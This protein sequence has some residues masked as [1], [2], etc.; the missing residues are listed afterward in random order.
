MFSPEQL[1][2]GQYKEADTRIHRL[3]ARIKLIC[4]LVLVWSAFTCKAG[5]L[6]A[7]IVTLAA[8]RLSRLSFRL[9]FKWVASLKWF[10]IFTLV[11]HTLATP[12][13][14]ISALSWGNGGITYEGLFNGGLVSLRL[15]ILL[16]ASSLLT[17]TT[18][19]TR[20]VSGLER[21]LSPLAKLGVP[22][23]DIAMMIMLS[24]H[25][26][27]IL[28]QEA[29]RIS[30]AQVARGVNFQQGNLLQRGKQLIPLIIPLV[31]GA[32]R[33]ADNLALALEIRHYNSRRPRTS[34][35]PAQLQAA[36]YLALA[37]MAGLP[38]LALF[39]EAMWVG[40]AVPTF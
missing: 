19:P 30:K 2:L 34:L 17:L 5:S 29:E 36:D 28:W 23:Q 8:I 25:F 33:R 16:M 14:F 24:L 38:W 26:I 20:L 13:H 15:I 1:S 10:L 37:G 31:L 35:Y 18:S 6:L 12:G 27:P 9:I 32:F 40:W 22:V 21:L 11:F 3:D 39:L 4:L 7:L